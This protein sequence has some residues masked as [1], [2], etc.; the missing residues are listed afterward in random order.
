MVIQ[1]HPEFRPQVYPPTKAAEGVMCQP[2]LERARQEVQA[3]IIVHG[4]A[5]CKKCWSNISPPTLPEF[6]KRKPVAARSQ[7][8]NVF[9]P[10]RN[11]TQ[12]GRHQSASP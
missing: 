12:Q 3:F 4:T 1:P 10:M 11:D 5:F 8:A 7:N 2:H 9:T 6:L